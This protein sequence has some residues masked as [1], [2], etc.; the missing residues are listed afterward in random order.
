MKHV[1]R[2]IALF[3]FLTLA[4]A[5]VFAIVIKDRPTAQYLNGNVIV[6]WTTADESG[7]KMFKI[8]R[9]P[10]SRGT[11]EGFL[12]VGTIER[13]QLKGNNSTYE[14]IDTDVF[15]VADRVFAYRIRVVFQNNTFSDSDIATTAVLSSAAKRTWGS[16]KAMFR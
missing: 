9:A 12:E 1:T 7:V 3:L 13:A 4:I 15:K 16:I 5:T 14:F 2:L 10:V 6:R 8:L 11:V